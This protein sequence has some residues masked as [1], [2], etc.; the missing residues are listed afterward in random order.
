[1]RKFGGK[2]Y[3]IYSAFDGHEL[4]YA[5]SDDPLSGFEFGGTLVSNG[6]VGMP[7]V[8]KERPKN[9]LGNTHGSLIEIG[10]KYYV[11][12]HRHTNRHAF[13]RQACAEEITFAGGRFLQAEMT[14]CGLN[15]G[16][17]AGK[18]KYPA[19]IAC[20]LYSEGGMH[21]CGVL[22]YGK[23]KYP[24]FT[25][26]GKDR[27]ENDDQYIANFCDGCVAAYKYFDLK[28]SA[29]IE[30]EL[31]GPGGGRLEAGVHPG[32]PIASAEVPRG[33]GVRRVRIP[34]ALPDGKQALYL[35][36]RG[37]GRVELISFTLL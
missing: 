28:G 5:V 33:S 14:S 17:L 36:Y 24:Y 23:G 35:R 8:T 21:F 12:Y 16:P 3:F 10:G 11:F 34:A 27:E 1:M 26:S 7:G 31:R 9:D 20:N 30:I 32:E 22:K 37:K 15:G 19:R 25:Q 29:G 18:G 13:S 2:Y 4:C 6:D